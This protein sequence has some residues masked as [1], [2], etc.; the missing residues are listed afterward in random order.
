MNTEGFKLRIVEDKTTLF[1][2]LLTTRNKYYG[3]TFILIGEY[4]GTKQHIK[5]STRFGVCEMKPT[6]LL[7]GNKPDI[8]TAID[9][10]DYCKRLVSYKIGK[11]PNYDIVDYKGSTEVIV[12]DGIGL[13]KM[14]LDSLCKGYMPS[15]KSAINKNE[16]LIENIKR[17]NSKIDFNNVIIFSE[18]KSNKDKMFIQDNN[19]MYYITPNSLIKGS[20]L[21]INNVVDKTEYYL[22]KF[23]KNGIDYSKVRYKNITDIVEF[24]CLEHNLVFE[25]TL[26]SHKKCDFCCPICCRNSSYIFEEWAKIRPENKGIFYI[27]KCYNDLESFYKFGITCTSISERYSNSKNMPYKFKI[28]INI[29]DMDREYIWNLEKTFENLI[30]STEYKYRPNIFFKGS[31]NECFKIEEE[32]VKDLIKRSTELKIFYKEDY[33]EV[34]NKFRNNE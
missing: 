30:Q 28:I 22:N 17:N 6:Q 19:G 21:D 27:I 23:A 15:I 8:S 5:L 18:Y 2:E 9:K 4:R 29:E 20:G 11:I 16:Y 33:I 1:K 26:N 10:L 3:K 7:K 24:R 31:I 14:T 25:Q 12:F 34:I 13:C 32:K